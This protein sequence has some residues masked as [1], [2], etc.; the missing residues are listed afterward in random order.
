MQNR[1]L[2]FLLVAMFGCVE[3]NDPMGARS[4]PANLIGFW[5]DEDTSTDTLEFIK[6]EDGSSLM[7]LNRGREFSHGHDLPKIGSGHYMFEL[8]SNAITLQ[9]SLSSNW[10]PTDY[11]FQYNS[12]QLKIGRFFESDN[13][14]SILTFRK[15][16]KSGL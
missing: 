15:V 13:S 3:E 8:K 1:L 16:K 11:H 10:N 12:L 6:L 4:L 9:Y 7:L 2:L 5:V 14:A